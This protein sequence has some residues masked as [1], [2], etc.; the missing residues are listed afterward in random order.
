M[1]DPAKIQPPASCTTP[2]VSTSRKAFVTGTGENQSRFMVRGVALASNATIVPDDDLLRDEHHD[3]LKE[4]ILPQLVALKANAVRV[5]SVHPAAKHKKSMD[6]LAAN[7]IY[8]M[9]GLSSAEVSI[10]MMSPQYIYAL[11]VRGTQ[12]IDE[13]QAYP[14]TLAFITS[15]ELIFPGEI[16]SNTGSNVAE[17]VKIE[18]AAAAADKS[19]MRDMKTYMANSKYRPI[20]IGPAMQ[21]G[22]QSTLNPAIIG[23]DVAAQFYAYQDPSAPL[24]CADFIGINTY[25]YLAGGPLSSYDG[26][27]NEVAMLDIP[28]FLTESGGI[29]SSSP[30][31][32][33]WKIVPHMYTETLL[34]DNLSGQVAF[35]FFEMD[36]QEMGLYTQLPYPPVATLTPT[37]YGGAV[38]LGRMFVQASGIPI[39]T[40]PPVVPPTSAPPTCDPALLPAFS[41]PSAQI[42]FENYSTDAITVV[43]QGAVMGVMLP[44]SQTSPVSTVIM[45]DPA[46][47]VDLLDNTPPNIWAFV[48]K[49]AAGT[50]SSGSTVTDNIQ[51]GGFC[52]ILKME[53][54][55]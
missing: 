6:L 28:V 16:Y 42:T 38:A 54:Q 9:V 12:I 31:E 34:A 44:G 20:P 26:L 1:N 33:D 55:A 25:R 51:W 8:A 49:V 22:P 53:P 13:F 4:V 23:T 3:Y 19:F 14:N 5:Y 18:L 52:P 48:C 37:I 27:A 10:P 29:N 36:H 45:I 2:R 47:E 15:N 17:T 39:V 50:L 21:D 30:V 32:R 43:Q 35:Q 46:L 7:G 41:P 24:A 11:Y 40:P